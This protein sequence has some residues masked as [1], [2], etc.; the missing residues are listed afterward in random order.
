MSL[1][2][3]TATKP[4]INS[5]KHPSFEEGNFC[6]I[7]TLGFTPPQTTI[8][9]GPNRLICTYQF[10]YIES[11]SKACYTVNAPG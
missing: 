2:M 4:P 3:S 10:F 9:N 8:Y 6:E 5:A 1:I 7:F 11:F